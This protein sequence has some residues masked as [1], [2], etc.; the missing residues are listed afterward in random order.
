MVFRLIKRAAGWRMGWRWRGKSR[1][2]ETGKEANV[3]VQVKDTR[4]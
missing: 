3:M 2:Q 4:T 1:G